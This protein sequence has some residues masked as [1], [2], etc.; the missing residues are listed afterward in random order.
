MIKIID[1]LTRYADLITPWAVAV[2]K[3]M[4]A[5][6]NRRNVTAWREQGNEIGKG[7][8]HLIEQTPVGGVLRESLGRQVTLI[9]SLPLEA[10][11]RVQETV[12]NELPRGT[13]SITI[14][15]EILAHSNI[16]KWRAKLIARTEV[17][18]TA[19]ELTK[20]RAIALGSEGYIWNRVGDYDV[21]D[22]HKAMAGK[23]VRWDSPPTFPHEPTLG[24]Y[25]AG[26][27]PNCRCW[28]KPVLPDF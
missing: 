13:R 5:D 18:R 10:A 25:H 17:S 1:T 7:I 26:C 22:D 24:A 16:P 20:A 3:Y 12:L 23:Y 21:R 14:A 4:I 15:Q 19:E 8:R 9:K 28:A 27:G 2:G 11:K 6:V